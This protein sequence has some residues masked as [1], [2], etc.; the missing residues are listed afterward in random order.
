VR[1]SFEALRAS[2]ASERLLGYALCTDDSLTTLSAVACTAESLAKSR[3]PAARWLP[4]EWS[5]ADSGE[6]FAFVRELLEASY[7]ARGSTGF[8]AHV[9]RAFAVCVESLGELRA[10]RSIDDDVLLVA[11]S[12]D[13]DP[14][15]LE[16]AVAGAATLN[17]PEVA[18]GFRRAACG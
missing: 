11:V 17:S 8:D 5:Y 9:E 2:H 10:R 15:F 13:P 3:A 6:R 16:W 18:E 12:T 14:L 4:V 7:R 1:P